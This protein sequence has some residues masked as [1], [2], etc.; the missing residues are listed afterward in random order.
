MLVNH[1][2]AVVGADV[3]TATVAAYLFDR[4]CRIQL[5]A[6]AAGGWPTWSSA[7]ESAAKRAH[8]YP[9]PLLTGA[10]D[11]LVRRLDR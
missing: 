9:D 8:C 4:A 5:T 3:R 10:W 6:M 1:G 11:Y 2:I 7:D